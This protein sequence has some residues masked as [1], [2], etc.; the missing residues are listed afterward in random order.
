MLHFTFQNMRAFY[1]PW[2]RGLGLILIH[3]VCMNSSVIT[4]LYK[5]IFHTIDLHKYGSMTRQSRVG[6]EAGLP[7]NVKYFIEFFKINK[8]SFANNL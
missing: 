2:L 8:H 3:V 7:Q 5:L 4:Q 6:S 1:G